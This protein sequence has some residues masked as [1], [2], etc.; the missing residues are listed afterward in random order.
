MSTRSAIIIENKDG[1]AEGIYCHNNGEPEFKAPILL[2][3]YTT[4]AK[5]RE[6]IALG[7]ISSLGPEIG[8]KHK[9]AAFASEPEVVTA[10]HRD[11]DDEG[12]NITF[13]HDW[14][15]VAAQIDHEHAYIFNVAALQWDHATRDFGAKQD[16]N[17][18]PLKDVRL[19]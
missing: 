9:F 8:S 6:L 5:V 1:S 3:H 11:R 17:R 12:P 14:Q 4:E 16:Q 10:Y 15:A 7:D 18:M 2:Q 19:E 13:G